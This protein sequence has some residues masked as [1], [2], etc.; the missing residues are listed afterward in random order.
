MDILALEKQIQDL[1]ARIREL[2]KDKALSDPKI[3]E[4]SQKLDELLMEYER[5][6]IRKMER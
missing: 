2:A 4:T 1:R 5:L 6:I 3:V